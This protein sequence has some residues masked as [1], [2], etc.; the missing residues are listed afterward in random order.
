MAD[1]ALD[2]V[3]LTKG[4]T[5][6]SEMIR[7]L[8]AAGF[9]RSVI[10]DFIGVRYQFVRNVIV[11]EERRQARREAG[12]TVASAKLPPAGS[13]KIKVGPH[14]T[15]RL[16]D[17]LRRELAVKEG[18]TLIASV[19]DGELRL[20]TIPAAVRRAQA[21]VREVVPEGVNLVDELLADR[22]REVEREKDDA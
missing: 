15:V 16:P 20:L 21:I 13:A 8:H 9:S 1:A 6:K 12:S 14:G 18:D 10:A 19:D 22:R 11:D 5:N 7:R 3:G 4:L 17:D 2:M